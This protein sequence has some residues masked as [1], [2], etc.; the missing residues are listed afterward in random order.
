METKSTKVSKSEIYSAIDITDEL[1]GLP[2]DLKGDLKEQIG[3]LIVEQILESL[4]D[5]RSPV[6]GGDYKTKLS[7]G[8]AK[9]KQEETGST[10]ANL[11]LSGEMINAIDYRIKGNTI[12]IGVFDKTNAGKADGHNNFS[13]M[14]KLPTRQFLPKEGQDFRNDI[15]NLIEETVEGF[16][17][18]NL[19]LD[20]KKLESIETKSELYSYL[21]D[22]L[23]VTGRAAVRD[24]VLGS[25][26]LV[27]L[28]DDFDL[29]DLIDG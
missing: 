19:E 27:E 11:D 16:K 29:L 4:A 15:K 2:V 23:G 28:L 17:A 13:G 10:E 6:Q 3:E 7:K 22:E 9:K 12:Q 25:K 1:K 5:V 18:D 20:E 8:Y 24:A 21:Q 14:S 26:N